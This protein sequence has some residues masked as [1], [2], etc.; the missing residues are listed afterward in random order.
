MDVR[1]GLGG[2]A[3]TKATLDLKDGRDDGQWQTREQL[4]SS[5]ILLLVS[6]PS[7]PHLYRRHRLALL[8]DVEGLHVVCSVHNNT[9]GADLMGGGLRWVARPLELSPHFGQAS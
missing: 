8:G 4:T 6:P 7:Q 5:P 3:G 1:E 2:G 9:A